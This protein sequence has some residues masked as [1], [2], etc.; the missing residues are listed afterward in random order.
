M[1][2]E[3]ETLCKLYLELA[4]VVPSSCISSREKRMQRHIDKY[5][6]V[7]MMIAEGC[8][9]PATVA[10]EVLNKMSSPTPAEI[11]AFDRK[12]YLDSL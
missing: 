1:N 12:N 10:R 4:N 9:A 2:M 11:E 5:G 8:A 7:L 3:L 6:V